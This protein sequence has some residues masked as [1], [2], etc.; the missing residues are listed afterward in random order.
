MNPEISI[1]TSYYNRRPQF[2]KT[3]EVLNKHP[4]KN[5]EVIVVDDASDEEHRLEDCLDFSFE[6]T[7]IRIDPEHKTY[8]NPCVPF[9]IGFTHARGEKI[10]IQN[11][12]C[13]HAGDLITV[14]QN[15][16]EN[17]YISFHCYSFDDGLTN[18]LLHVDISSIPFHDLTAQLRASIFSLPQVSCDQQYAP[19]WFNHVDI[20]PT[21][22]HF[23]SAILAKDLK[24]LGGFDE[25]YALGVGWDDNEFRDRIIKK[26]MN[27]EFSNEIV[28][29]QWHGMGNYQASD[30]NKLYL[31]NQKLYEN[32]TMKE[33][34]WQIKSRLNDT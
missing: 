17:E 8:R 9:N 29:H 10:I 28:I 13:L 26:G 18:Q 30:S 6:T 3:L 11:P 25:R 27:V 15:I 5:F 22:F 23:A 4:N 34:T 20:R 7:L 32:V 33:K 19:S 16:K 21:K 24:D 12:E 1:V 2:L 31:Q 14:A